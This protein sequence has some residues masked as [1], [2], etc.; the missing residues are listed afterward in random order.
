MTTQTNR[1]KDNRR[2]AAAVAL[3]GVG[4]AGLATAS[5][6][7]LTVDATDGVASGVDTSVTGLAGARATLT[8]TPTAGAVPQADGSIAVD[9]TV[10]VSD[11]PAGADLTEWGGTVY[12]DG[13]QLGTFDP[14][15]TATV[16]GLTSHDELT[17]VAVVLA[18]QP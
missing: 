14:S 2:R 10:A 12:V 18:K 16:T 8:T 11:V 9:L 7:M 5:A 3:V 6:S 13:T 15:S 4:I 17:K 1:T